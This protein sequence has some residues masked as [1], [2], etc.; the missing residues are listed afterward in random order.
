MLLQPHSS[1]IVS[2]PCIPESGCRGQL[3]GEG[4]RCLLKEDVYVKRYMQLYVIAAKR[5]QLISLCAYLRVGAGGGK[6]LRRLI[7]QEHSRG[8][9]TPVR[10]GLHARNPTAVLFSLQF[11]HIVAWGNAYIAPNA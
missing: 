11:L 9:R 4:T 2:F 6:K 1:T 8:I 7:T 10:A 3:S 5:H